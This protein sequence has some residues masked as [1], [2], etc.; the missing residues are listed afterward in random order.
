MSVRG[1]THTV[2]DALRGLPLPPT[3]RWSDGVFDREVLQRDGVEVSIFA[4]R[5]RDHQ[6]PHARDEL[7]FVA[8]GSATFAMG[9]ATRAVGP[10]DLIFVPAGVEHRFHEIGADFATWVVF[11]GPPYE[12]TV[13]TRPPNSDGD[14]RER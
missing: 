5:P 9:G 10:G 8:R 14:A 6:Q 4:P 11:F 12:A 7:Y 2:D 3:A 13:E 1:V